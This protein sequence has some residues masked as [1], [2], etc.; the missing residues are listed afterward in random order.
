MQIDELL[1]LMVEKDASDLHIKV[2]S[3]PTLRIHGRL[4]PIE[5]PPLRTEDTRE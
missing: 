3:P 4:Y 1:K 5:L 2:G